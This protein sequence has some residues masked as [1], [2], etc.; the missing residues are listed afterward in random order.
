MRRRNFIGTTVVKL[1]HQRGWTQEKLFTVLTLKGC[2][3]T[4][5][6]LA[7]IETGRAPVDDGLIVFFAKAFEVRVEA[8]F[9]DHLQDGKKMKHLDKLFIPRRLRFSRNEE[10]S[11]N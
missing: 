1:R 7:N 3:I 9:P 8:L 2:V 4:R 5:V 10:D 11:F 6:T